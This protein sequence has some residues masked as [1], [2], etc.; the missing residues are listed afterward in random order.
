MSRINR[1]EDKENFKRMEIYL[2]NEHR[3]Q[4]KSLKAIT[5]QSSESE[6]IEKIIEFYIEHLAVKLFK[7]IN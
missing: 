7:E 4:L 6:T 1:R 5:N 3:K 2:T